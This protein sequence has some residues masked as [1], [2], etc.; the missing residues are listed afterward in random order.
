MD[1]LKVKD[2]T[3]GQWNDIPAIIG[4]PGPSG[5]NSVYVGNTEPSDT[6]I[7]VWIDTDDDA[8]RIVDLVYPIGSIYMSV[9]SSS[10]VVLFGGTW[11]RIQ[12]TFLLAAGNTY[13]GGGTGG[14][15]KHTHEYGIQYGTYYYN[16]VF[17]SDSNA[18]VLDYAADG[19]ITV[20]PGENYG[21]S[22]SVHPSTTGTATG[23]FDHGRATGNASYESN[24]PPYLV[25]YMWKRTA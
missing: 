3:T 22:S 9:N 10:P 5:P 1:I 16:T 8:S 17:E 12:D 23:A 15:E 21:T 14:A 20:S 4:P 18:G 25:V 6:N 13:S 7:R 2:S 11:E 24:M 19:T